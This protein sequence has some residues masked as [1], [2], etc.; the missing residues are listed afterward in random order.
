MGDRRAQATRALDAL[1]ALPDLRVL[2]TSPF[3]ESEP[4]GPPQPWY[5]NAAVAVQTERSAQDLL[6]ALLGIETALGRTRE[7][8]ERWGPR[9]LDLDLLLYDQLVCHTPTLTLPHPEVHRRRFVL[10]PLADIAPTLEHPVLRRSIRAL[11]AA[12]AD[13]KQVRAFPP[14]G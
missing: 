6:A 12:V 7:G 14:A 3:Y 13:E 9:A 5:L 1:A 11:L 4:W 8:G 10:Q 2:L